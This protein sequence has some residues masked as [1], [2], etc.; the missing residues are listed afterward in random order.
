MATG[1][2]SQLKLSPSS[3]FL[4]CRS[5]VVGDLTLN[6]ATELVLRD[7]LDRHEIILGL[8]R[9]QDT[10]IELVEVLQVL[11]GGV[12]AVTAFVVGDGL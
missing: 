12:A 5:G 8:P 2:L 4:C 11:V 10:L 1:R 6:L 7:G 9:I 3:L